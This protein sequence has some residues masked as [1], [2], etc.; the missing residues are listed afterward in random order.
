MGSGSLP[1]T[2]HRHLARA[3]LCPASLA[4]WHPGT[5]SVCARPADYLYKNP[6]SGS[7]SRERALRRPLTSSRADTELV[8]GPS[9]TPFGWLRT[10]PPHPVC[11]TKRGTGPALNL[12]Q[13]WR[14]DQSWCLHFHPLLISTPSFLSMEVC[15]SSPRPCNVFLESWKSKNQFVSVSRD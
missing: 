10:L 12:L 11:R 4:P 13:G 7:A 5:C 14:L 9:C 6:S 2:A 3:L 15:K 1:Q 8:S